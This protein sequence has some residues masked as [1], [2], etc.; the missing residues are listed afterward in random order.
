M[1]KR[2]TRETLQEWRLLTISDL[3]RRGKGTRGEIDEELKRKLLLLNFSEREIE[4]QISVGWNWAE[5]EDRKFITRKGHQWQLTRSG[6]TRAQ[7]LKQG[8]KRDLAR[9][10][11]NR[12]TR[13]KHRVVND[14][15][16]EVGVASGKIRL[17]QRYSG[18]PHARLKQMLEQ[19][20]RENSK[21]LTGG[22]V[23]CLPRGGYEERMAVEN[24]AIKHILCIEEKSKWQTTP[25]NN[26]G[27]DLY[28]VDENGRKFMWCEVKAISGKFDARH[29][30]S[31][32]RREF[33]EAQKRGDAY[34]LYVVENVGSYDTRIIKI[35][36]PAGKAERFRFGE[37][38]HQFTA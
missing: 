11:T 22:S 28:R 25:I 30:V 1:A 38:W 31:L 9:M 15:A 12:K 35:Q 20:E 7:A 4:A 26:P 34:W 24:A 6:S 32:T 27:F 37:R 13:E 19:W 18:I 2:L 10:E 3:G 36:D 23:E 16:R 14:L 21:D 29:P 33:E 17:L 5:L 8:K